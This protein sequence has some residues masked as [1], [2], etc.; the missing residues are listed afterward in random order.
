MSVTRRYRGGALHEW[1]ASV[2][3]SAADLLAG[4]VFW[5]VRNAIGLSLGG[6]NITIYPHL[7]WGVGWWYRQFWV[8]A[9]V[10]C[11]DTDLGLMWVA[12]AAL[13]SQGSK[14]RL[15]ADI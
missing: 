4:M 13:E 12:M 8:S 14:S 1:A 15:R 10:I 2:E 7:G 9:K 3:C 6:S 11:V 5:L